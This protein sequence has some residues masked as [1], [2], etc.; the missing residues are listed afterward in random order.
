MSSHE[1]IKSWVVSFT[2]GLYLR[3]CSAVADKAIAE[4]LVQETFIAAFQS[5]DKF[6]SESSPQTWLF[7]ILNNKINDHY[8]S[9]QKTPVLSKDTTF[10]GYFFDDH[11]HWRESEYPKEWSDADLHL[12]DN[13]EFKNT[14][15]KCRRNL[16]E[17]WDMV[18]QLKYIDQRDGKEI[19]QDLN[20]TPS[21]FWQLMHRAKLQLRK[22]LEL[23]WFKK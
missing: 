12:L 5:F 9:K 11:G 1:V 23:H 22:C 2:D 7:A 21:N 14:L 15:Q 13:S 3:A 16:P 8:R 19:C 4:D 17:H 10:F 20:I 18:L 6:R